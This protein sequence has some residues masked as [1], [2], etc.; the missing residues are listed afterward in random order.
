M[1]APAISPQPLRRARMPG[2]SQPPP[3]AGGPLARACG[4]CITAVL[5]HASVA[6]HLLSILDGGRAR[7]HAT[8]VADGLDDRAAGRAVRLPHRDAAGGGTGAGPSFFRRVG[9]GARPAFFRGSARRSEGL[10]RICKNRNVKPFTTV[11]GRYLA[12][13]HVYTRI[14]GRPPA[15]SDMQRYFRVT[16]PAVH[17]MVVTLARNG[18][19]SRTPGAPRS[20]EV[21]VKA[22]DLPLLEF[23]LSSFET[24]S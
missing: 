21:L 23:L 14:H 10:A 13:I 2:I 24:S 1:F 3:D 4:Y 19:I 6:A 8:R 18:L 5:L 9:A 17:Q 15:E 20:I 7:P 16:P 11:Q 12:F 22:E